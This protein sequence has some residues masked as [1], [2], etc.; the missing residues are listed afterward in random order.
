MK[1]KHK[2]KEGFYILFIYLF[3]YS[4]KYINNSIYTKKNKVQ[5]RYS[6]LS[7]SIQNGYKKGNF[8]INKPQKNRRIHGI[9]SLSLPQLWCFLKIIKETRGRHFKITVHFFSPSIVAVLSNIFN[10]IY[11]IISRVLFV[12]FKLLIFRCLKVN[13]PLK[14]TFLGI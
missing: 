13:K 7:L 1:Y 2:G 3:V 5:F 8:A 11:I 10:I 9:E 14:R 12:I 4:I 6:L